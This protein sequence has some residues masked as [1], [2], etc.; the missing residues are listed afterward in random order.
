LLRDRLPKGFE[1]AHENNTN[2]TLKAK[3]PVFAGE[4]V[5]FSPGI[6]CLLVSAESKVLP[7]ASAGGLERTRPRLQLNVI[8]QQAGRWRSS[9]LNLLSAVISDIVS[10]LAFQIAD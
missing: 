1:S 7:D 2:Q 4:S 9:Q 3:V 6:L 8:K 10:S 5:A